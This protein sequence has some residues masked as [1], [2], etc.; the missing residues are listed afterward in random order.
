MSVHKDKQ[1]GKWYAHA[2]YQD[3]RGNQM[4]K[5]KRGFN[6]KKEAL[7]WEREYLLQRT[8]DLT[9]SFENFLVLYAEDRRPRLKLNTWLSKEY[10][11]NAKLL[12]FFGKMAMNEIEAKDIIRWQN[13]LINGHDKNGKPYSQTYLK[14]IHNQLTAIFTHAYKFYGLK[15]NPASKAGSMGKKNADEMRF[16]TRE[17]YSKFAEIAMQN[18]RLYYPVEILYWCGLRLGEM[19]ALTFADVDLDKKTLRVNKSYQSIKG[20]VVITEPKTP[21]SRRTVTIPDF[22]C[23]SIQD[24]IALQYAFKPSDRMFGVSK[25]YLAYHLK[26]CAD[27]AGVERIRVHDLRHSHVSLLIEL[28]FSALAIAERVGHESIEVTYRYAHLFPTKQTE[29]AISL[30]R[31]GELCHAF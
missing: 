1:S 13:S 20:Q 19:L 18:Q 25:S 26:K 24:Y 30:D 31:E 22:L 7:A 14:T 2:C 8:D 27:V 3:G 16:W 21:K 6:T 28:G 15:T 29:I 12:P 4:R 23:S 9:M 11:I 17:E 10:I 5:M